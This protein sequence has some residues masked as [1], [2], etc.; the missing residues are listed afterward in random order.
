MHRVCG[1]FM[2]NLMQALHSSQ[3]GQ[4]ACAILTTGY[5]FP[6]PQAAVIL[7]IYGLAGTSKTVVQDAFT[8]LDSL[9]TYL[10]VGWT[11]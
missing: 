2:P 11:R 3:I 8:T 1:S 5:E 9:D 10:K 7:Y 4:L 6:G